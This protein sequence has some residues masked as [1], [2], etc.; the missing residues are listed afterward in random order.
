M[1][2]TY[3]NSSNVFAH[4]RLIIPTKTGE[5]PSDTLQFSKQK[6]S[7]FR[8]D[9]VRGQISEHTSAPNGAIVYVDLYNY[10]FHSSR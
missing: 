9:T 3:Y 7:F 1:Y 5:Y 10:V 2:I 6:C 4:L 8:T